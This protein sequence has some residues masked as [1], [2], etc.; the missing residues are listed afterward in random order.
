MEKP[1]LIW[2]QYDGREEW[3][4]SNLLYHTAL[5][6]ELTDANGDFTY[7][8]YPMV[9]VDNPADYLPADF[10]GVTLCFDPQYE[11]WATSIEITMHIKESGV[12]TYHAYTFTGTGPYVWCPITPTWDTAN[13][14]IVDFYVIIY[15]AHRPNSRLRFT[16][17]R[18][19]H[20][21]EIPNDFLRSLDVS[22][23]CDLSGISAP[24]SKM[25]A[26]IDAAGLDAIL[27]YRQKIELK[28]NIRFVGE[29]WVDSIAKAGK[30]TYTII[31]LDALGCLAAQKF[32]GANYSGTDVSTVIDDIIGDEYV[33]WFW[34]D[35]FSGTVTGLI[36]ECD[37]RTAL[38]NLSISYGGAV[39]SKFYHLGLDELAVFSPMT[40]PYGGVFPISPEKT[41]INPAL[42]YE[43]QVTSYTITS[44]SF[45][46]N[47]NGDVAIGNTRYRDTRTENTYTRS[48]PIG[49]ETKKT[50]SQATLITSGT[51]LTRAKNLLA[52]RYDRQMVWKGS[53]IWDE[54]SGDH[55]GRL[56]AWVSIQDGEGNEIR[57]AIQRAD[58]VFSGASI[59]V[60]AEILSFQLLTTPVLSYDEMDGYFTASYPQGDELQLYKNGE[61]VTAFQDE[62]YTSD[63]GN[64]YV[65]AIGDNN[66]YS[67][68]SNT[69]TIE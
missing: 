50:V 64:Y 68:H 30:K 55:S 7:P 40:N 9:L 2:G 57:G 27:G 22:Q 11:N 34:G 35:V 53:F 51:P 52:G 41:Y 47:T 33:T 66:A 61:Y 49:N 58:L 32:P 59:K 18:F 29:Y 21:Y 23:S 31:A 14:T 13:D 17:M 54:S 25:T 20:S 56:G 15:S 48:V 36:P 45:A 16:S 43:D 3:I 4:N 62:Y 10:T 19:G 37:R 65:V 63:P 6:N 39:I 60:N 42:V 12:S 26:V 46:Q 69:I 5:F 8:N 28:T 44:H 1:T 24:F 67:Y 38:N